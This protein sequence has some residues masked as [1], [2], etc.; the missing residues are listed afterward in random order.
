MKKKETN[1]HKINSIN[2]WYDV[3]RPT[4]FCRPYSLKFSS[5]MSA[6]KKCDGE[7]IGDMI[8]YCDTMVREEILEESLV[9]IL[10]DMKA[11]GKS[12]ADIFRFCYKLQNMSAYAFLPYGI[13]CAMEKL[14]EWEKEEKSAVAAD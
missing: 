1:P 7:R 9:R 5:V 12:D 10:H 4:E 13:E 6:L 14:A 11:K 8:G 3:K 2:D